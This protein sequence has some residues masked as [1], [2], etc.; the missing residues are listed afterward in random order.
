MRQENPRVVGESTILTV[1][2]EPMGGMSHLV[3]ATLRKRSVTR[4]GFGGVRPLPRTPATHQA[5]L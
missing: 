5:R 3:T 2:G 4:F 1:N